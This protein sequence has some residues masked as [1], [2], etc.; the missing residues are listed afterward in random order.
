MFLRVDTVK[1]YGENKME[2]LNSLLADA[3]YNSFVSNLIESWWLRVC[4]YI[5]SNYEIENDEDFDNYL[6]DELKLDRFEDLIRSNPV[7]YREVYFWEN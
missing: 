2:C 7:K 5:Y 3:G 4:D 1:Y 6:T